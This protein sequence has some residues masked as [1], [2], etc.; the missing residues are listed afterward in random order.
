[1][2]EP[3][4]ARQIEQDEGQLEGIP[5]AVLRDVDGALVHRL[6][7]A[8]SERDDRLDA[9]LPHPQI[10]ESEGVCGFA[11]VE[12]QFEP[13]LDPLERDLAPSQSPPRPASDTGPYRAS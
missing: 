2:V 11:V 13:L 1:M 9:L 8:S 12:D 7:T 10:G 3:G 6:I 4:D 5:G